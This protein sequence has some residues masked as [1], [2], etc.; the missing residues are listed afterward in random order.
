MSKTPEEIAEAFANTNGSGNETH[1][2]TFCEG[3]LAGQTAARL[4]SAKEIMHLQ[5]QLSE[6]NRKIIKMESER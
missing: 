3:Y 5:M 6:A 1:D 4:E 2:H